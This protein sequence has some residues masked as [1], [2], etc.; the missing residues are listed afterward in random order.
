MDNTNHYRHI[1]R[2]LIQ[3]YAKHQPACGEV[4]IEEI[5]DETNDHY[6]LMYA[7]WN[8]SYRIHCSVLHL[9]SGADISFINVRAKSVGLQSPLP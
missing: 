2:E 3:R 6:E 9:D 4:Q 5:F 7:G 1:I 8:G